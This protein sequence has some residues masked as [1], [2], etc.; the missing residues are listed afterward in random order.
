MARIPVLRRDS[1][2]QAQ[3]SYKAV[4]VYKWCDHKTTV[5]A[6]YYYLPPRAGHLRAHENAQRV[7]WSHAGVHLAKAPG[8]EGTGALVEL[9]YL[10][11]YYHGLLLMERSGRDL[12]NKL[13]GQDVRA[14][15]HASYSRCSSKSSQEG[16]RHQSVVFLHGELCQPR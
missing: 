2:V 12:I 6:Q 11:L 13:N 14:C 7:T 4:L 15:H 8:S 3:A 9:A 10:P 5:N 16:W 1:R